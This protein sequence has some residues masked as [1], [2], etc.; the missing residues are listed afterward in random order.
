MTGMIGGCFVF[1]FSLSVFVYF[2]GYSL[3]LIDIFTS[4][5]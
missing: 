3:R 2:T 4:W 5:R 1:G